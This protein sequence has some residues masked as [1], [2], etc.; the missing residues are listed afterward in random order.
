M[1]TFVPTMLATP[2]DLSPEEV[3]AISSICETN[4]D[5]VSSN[6]LQSYLDQ[7]ERRVWFLFEIAQGEA[8][9]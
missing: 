9:S 7:T 1:T 6:I 4:H 2:T 5:T 8:H 3:H